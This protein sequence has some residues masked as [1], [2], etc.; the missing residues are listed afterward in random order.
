MCH[1]RCRSHLDPDVIRDI[2]DKL[3]TLVIEP[4]PKIISHSAIPTYD[5][6]P[7][8][9]QVRG[10]YPIWEHGIFYIPWLQPKKAQREA[11]RKGRRST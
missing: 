3:L 9:A 11:I 10:R 7:K 8:R 5:M 6:G 2:C 4:D 1:L